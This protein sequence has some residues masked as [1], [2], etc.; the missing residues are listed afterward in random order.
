M[1]RGFDPHRLIRND[2]SGSLDFV[3]KSDVTTPGR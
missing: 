3:V 2:R 1:V